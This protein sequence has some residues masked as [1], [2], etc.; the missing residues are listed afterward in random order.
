MSFRAHTAWAAA[1]GLGA[2]VLTSALVAAPAFASTTV[3]SSA[4]V[5]TGGCA[6]GTQLQAVS[7]PGINYSVPAVGCLLYTS[8]AADE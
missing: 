2:I 3:G 4:T 1:S 8:D 5:P 6:A 7:P